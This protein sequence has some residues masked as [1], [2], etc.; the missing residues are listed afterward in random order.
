[1]CGCPL[2][3]LDFLLLCFFADDDYPKMVTAASQFLGVSWFFNFTDEKCIH[4]PL[5]IEMVL[6]ILS[7]IWGSISVST[8]EGSR[9]SHRSIPEVGSFQYCLQCI[10]DMVGAA[11]L[12]WTHSASLGKK[13]PGDPK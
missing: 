3:L 9:K 7:Q 1:M 12:S 13:G 8:S 4:F 2:I 6:Y 5:Q 10:L 11:S